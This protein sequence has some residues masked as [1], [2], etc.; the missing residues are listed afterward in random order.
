MQEYD[1]T[2]IDKP[3]KDNVVVDILSR[4]LVNTSN[5]LVEE[6]FMGK[7]L[8]AVSNHTPFYANISNYLIARKFPSH[9]SPQER[10]KII[11][12]ST[13][14]SWVDGYLYYTGVD[15]TIQKYVRED[16]VQDILK[17]CHDG[18]C[19]RNFIDK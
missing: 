3:D 15:K 16:E 10:Q 8:F 18:P 5:S 14:F 7:K 13:R 9:V 12:K 19:G 1:I 17:T 2:I 4:P 6:V 11:Q